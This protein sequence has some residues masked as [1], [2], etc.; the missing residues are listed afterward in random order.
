MSTFGYMYDSADGVFP[1]GSR[2]NA[3]YFNGRYA[4]RPYQ[5][6]RGQIWIDVDGSAPGSCCCLQIDGFTQPQIDVMIAMVP[7]WL[8]RRNRIGRGVIYTDRDSLPAVVRAAMGRPW[9]LWLS[10]LDGTI[11]G[12][13]APA[14]AVS[15]RLIAV[16]AWRGAITDTSAVVN[17]DWWRARAA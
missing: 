9:D 11:P 13:I 16:Q 4:H 17:S 1:A 12:P 7:H 10:T 15:G 14:G 5:V 2:L 6:R 8:D 3:L